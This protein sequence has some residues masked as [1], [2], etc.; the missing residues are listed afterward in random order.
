MLKPYVKDRVK[1]YTSDYLHE[2]WGHTENFTGRGW[3]SDMFILGMT[4]HDSPEIKANEEQINIL[5]RLF[6]MPREKLADSK[7]FFNTKIAEPLRAK[8]SMLFFM[9]ALGLKGQYKD[10]IDKTLDF[11]TKINHNYQD[12][13]FKSL[14]KSEAF[15]PMDALERNFKAMGLDKTEPE[16]YRKIVKYRNI[17]AGNGNVTVTKIGTVTVL[18]GLF[19]LAAGALA[20]KL[21]G[22]NHKN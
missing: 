17:L 9:T 18:S 4:N 10:N 7:E 8:N 21:Y 22:S 14:K 2:N 20:L 11:R 5:S 16:L 19:I 15:N 1:I 6:K 13:Y 3:G 12:E